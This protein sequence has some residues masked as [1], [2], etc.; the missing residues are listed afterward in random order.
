M[1][2]KKGCLEESDWRELCSSMTGLSRDT[3]SLQR[4]VDGL[5]AKASD[6]AELNTAISVMSL[7][8]EHIVQHNATQD[9]LVERQAATLDKINDNLL[10][11]NKG[12]DTLEL[13]VDTLES[14]VDNNES[15]HTI[16]IREVE[17]IKQENYLIK[18][19][20]PMSFGAAISAI[21]LEAIKIMK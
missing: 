21:I 9:K 18:Y 5:E 19:A 6:L 15:L 10:S 7:T 17:K 13:K 14:R 4:R 8:L 12:Q 11:L 20:I 1:E 16:D 3:K 2:V